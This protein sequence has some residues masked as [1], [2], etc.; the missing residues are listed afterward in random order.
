[1]KCHGITAVRL[2]RKALILPVGFDIYA[3]EECSNPVGPARSSLTLEAM[4]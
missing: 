3:A 1:V 4:A 2:T